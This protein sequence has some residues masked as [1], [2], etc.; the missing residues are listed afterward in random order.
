MTFQLQKAQTCTFF[1]SQLRSRLV[2]LS[3]K[4]G[5]TKFKA[6]AKDNLV[7]LTTLLVGLILSVTSM[8]HLSIKVV[9]VRLKMNQRMPH[10]LMELQQIPTLHLQIQM[11]LLTVIE[12]LL[13][14][15]QVI[16]L[17]RLKLPHQIL[18]KKQIL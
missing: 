15:P 9:E 11:K 5:S 18:W 8:M 3:S 17:V 14:P 13:Q 2:I 10:K 1:L 12:R 6:A 4:F 16:I 7:A